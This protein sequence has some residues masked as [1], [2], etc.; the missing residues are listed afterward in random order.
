[1]VEENLKRLREISE[2]AD[3]ANAAKGT[4]EQKIGDFWATAMDSAKIEQQGLKPLQPYLDKI[5]RYQI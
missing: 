1:V 5:M 4:T 3:S 2:K